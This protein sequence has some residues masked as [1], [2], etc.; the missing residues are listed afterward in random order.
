M[1]LS[2]LC[3]TVAAI[4]VLP[5]VT[6]AGP[7][8]HLLNE[9]AALTLLQHTLKDDRVYTH[10]ISLECVTYGTEETTGAYFEFVLRENHSAKCGGDPETSP[11][12]DRY[13]VYRKF[14]K[15]E[16]LDRVQDTWQPYNPGK[17][18]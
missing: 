3:I 7:R 15:I 4:L 8:S 6:Y 16:W 11:V 10:R 12:V 14:R 18:R 13:R 5:I 2:T 1:E 9:D 17:I